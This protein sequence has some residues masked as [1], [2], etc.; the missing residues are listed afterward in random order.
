MLIISFKFS[1]GLEVFQPILMH[2]DLSSLPPDLWTIFWP[3]AG[4]SNHNFIPIQSS[5]PKRGHLFLR[6]VKNAEKSPISEILG[7]S[8]QNHI[9]QGF[10][11]RAKILNK[12]S[13][14]NQKIEISF[15]GSLLHFL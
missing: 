7:Y 9:N 2:W 8:N 5:I 6:D 14:E 4:N 1:A 15:A 12:I 13:T 3:L 10:L 11:N